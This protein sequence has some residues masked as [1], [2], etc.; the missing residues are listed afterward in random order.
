M[1]DFLDLIIDNYVAAHSNPEKHKLF[2]SDEWYEIY[3]M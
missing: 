3:L 1:K 2:A